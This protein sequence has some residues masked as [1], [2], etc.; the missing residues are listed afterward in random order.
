MYIS[1]KYLSCYNVIHVWVVPLNKALYNLHMLQSMSFVC[2][3]R[4][5]EPLTG[6]HFSVVCGCVCL[7]VHLV[8]KLYYQ[9]Y[10]RRHIII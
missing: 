10:R 8:V 3:L 6:I 2:P 5:A 1:D 7:S 9:S 4:L